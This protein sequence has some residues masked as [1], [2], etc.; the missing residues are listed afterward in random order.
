MCTLPV[1][2]WKSKKVSKC[3][4][5]KISALWARSEAIFIFCRQVSYLATIHCVSEDSI[6]GASLRYIDIRYIIT[7]RTRNLVYL[8]QCK[9]CSLQYVEE[10]ENALHVRMNGHRSDIRTRE[11]DKSVS[12]HFCQPDH[13]IV[14][15]V[16]SHPEHLSSLIQVHFVWSQSSQGEYPVAFSFSPP[17][18]TVFVNLLNPFHL[19]VFHSVRHHGVHMSKTDCCL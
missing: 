1:S 18:C 15:T 3:S 8:I 16:L 13:A 12:S 10:T 9:K 14:D 2:T 4:W 17:L 6:I 11:T 7:C 5:W 19:Q